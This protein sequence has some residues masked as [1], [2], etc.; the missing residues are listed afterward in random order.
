MTVTL[1][2]ANPADA[3]VI[4][5]LLE[6]LV[7]PISTETTRHQLVLLSGTGNDRVL[8]A[9][10]EGR[11]LGGVGLHWTP[12]LHWGQPLG[13]VTVLVVNEAVRGQGIG[14]ALVAEAERLLG[15]AGCG[16]AEVTSNVR[17]A[18]AHAFYLRLG[19]GQ[20]SA[21]FRR[22]LDDRPED[23]LR[24]SQRERQDP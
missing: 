2:D 8:V 3:Q 15:E 16:A 4:A 12:L 21:Y 5:D 7:H 19:Y 20:P 11:V 1:R 13:R 22:G 18:E 10:A 24:E 23:G 14:R 17:R 6:Q 9:E